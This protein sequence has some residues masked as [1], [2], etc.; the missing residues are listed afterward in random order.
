[1]IKKF[2]SNKPALLLWGARSFSRFGDALEMLAM[3]YLVYD[4]TG[5]GLAMGSL[6][7]FSVLPNAIISPLAGV[8][9]DKYNKN[10]IMFLSE[11]VRVICILLIPLLML[12]HSIQLWHIYLISVIVSIAESFFEPTAGITFF[13]VIGK[14]DMPLYNS[15]V[16]ISNHILRVLGYSLSGIFI[17]T[18]GKEIIFIIDAITFLASAIVSLIIKIPKL[19]NTRAKEKTNFKEDLF[20]GFKYVFSNKTIISIMFVILIVNF[21]GTPLDTYIPILLDRILKVS[22]VWSGYFATAAIIGAILG[23]ILYPI[24]NKT[25]FKLQHLYFYGLI[26]LGISMGLAGFI[27]TPIYYLVLFFIFGA[28]GSLISV[29]SFTEIQLLVDTIFLGRVSSILTMLSLVAA[30]LAGVVFGGLADMV[31]IPSIFIALTLPWLIIGVFSYF[32]IRLPA[33]S[34][35]KAIEDCVE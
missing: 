18:I 1:M 2:L 15:A 20:S 26:L 25:S 21:L 4:L 8:I 24:L 17:A 9:S 35:P 12:T 5:S 32:S 31:Y 3:L 33:A 27:L 13:L 7:L 16:T 6:M 29:W 11:M 14:E 19:E 10:K 28:I 23:N 22:K 30:P 34:S